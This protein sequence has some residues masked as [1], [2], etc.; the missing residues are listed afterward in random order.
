MSLYWDPASDEHKVCVENDTIFTKD[1]AYRAVC[2]CG[3][4]SPGCN[5]EQDAEAGAMIHLVDTRK[6]KL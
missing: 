6:G 5:Y 2:T 4:K 1:D 3:W